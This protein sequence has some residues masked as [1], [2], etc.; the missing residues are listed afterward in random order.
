[1]RNDRAKAKEMRQKGSSYAEISRKLGVPKGTLSLWFKNEPWSQAVRK[2]RAA[3]AARD[4]KSRVRQLPKAVRQYWQKVRT[5]YQT[6]AVKDFLELSKQALFL[7][8]IT[9]YWTRGD[10]SPGNSQVRFTSNDPDMVK[11]FYSFLLN[12]HL[13][14]QEQIRMRLVLYPDLIDTVQKKT[15]GRLL[16]I[17]DTMFQNSIIVKRQKK[18][19][20]F[21]SG[22][23]MILVHSRKLK[24][25]LLKWI[26]LYRGILYTAK[27]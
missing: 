11:L 1:M 5:G 4:A 27:I 25:K 18:S 20:R 17:P 10:T 14:S 16:G 6:E 3:Q 22:S 9:L 21:S 2:K 15:W 7:A 19:K 23:C 24:E 8:G 13:A 26:E 12:N